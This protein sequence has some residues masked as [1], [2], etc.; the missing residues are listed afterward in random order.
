MKDFVH[1]KIAWLPNLG[2][3]LG[4]FPCDVAGCTCECFAS[5]GKTDNC[6]NC[7]HD[8]QNHSVQ[9]EQF[10]SSLGGLLSQKLPQEWRLWCGVYDTTNRRAVQCRVLHNT[11]I[12]GV[13]AQVWPC[14]SIS[15]IGSALNSRQFCDFLRR[16]SAHAWCLQVDNRLFAA[17]PPVETTAASVVAAASSGGGGG[18]GG[19]ADD[20]GGGG[21]AAAAAAAAAASA[22]AEPF[23]CL[24]EGI[25]ALTKQR[26]R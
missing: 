3:C 15:Y 10:A 18:G 12:P 11:A 1:V 24:T 25:W 8:S 22:S 17:L 4:S 16:A 20:G 13:R 19:D 14:L 26:D 7:L 21:G 23:E 2:F 5:L 6:E 9:A